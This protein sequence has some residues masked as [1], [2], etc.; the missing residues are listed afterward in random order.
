MDFELVIPAYNESKNLPLVVQ[1][2]AEAALGQGFSPQ[3]FQLI[4]VENGSTDD[5]HDTLA[6]LAK[7]PLGAWFRVV[8]VFP[9]QGYGYGLM[10]GLTATS[11]PMIGW[12]HGDMQTDPL[13]AFIALKKLRERASKDPST[14]LL[15]KGARQGRNWKDVTV[16]HVFALCATLI[17][18]L[19]IKEI[20][21]QP[22]VFHR[23]L[24][25]ELTDPPVTFGFDLYALYKARKRGYVFDQISVQ[26]PNRPYGFSKWSA[27]LSSRRRTIVGLIRYMW[28]LRLV[29]GRI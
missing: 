14:K 3:T 12:S 2:C 8:K 18:G 27:T 17:L 19:K 22:K 23:A 5:S 24:L 7:G 1:R 11:A 4:I 29:E 15:V 13:D 6:R 21:A 26:F 28:H 9:N 25:T 10:R 16:S 20:N